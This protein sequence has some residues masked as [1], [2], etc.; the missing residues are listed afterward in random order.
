MLKI[1]TIRPSSPAESILVSSIPKLAEASPNS[2][3]SRISETN[4]AQLKSLS[5]LHDCVKYSGTNFYLGSQ[6]R[7]FLGEVWKDSMND[8]NPVKR[9]NSRTMMSLIKNDLVEVMLLYSPKARHILSQISVHQ[10]HLH[11]PELKKRKTAVQ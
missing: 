4:R 10:G 1:H 5:L 6:S 7:A 11:S 2:S 9:Q 3:S 8:H